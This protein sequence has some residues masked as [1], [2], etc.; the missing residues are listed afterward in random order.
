MVPPSKAP[1]PVPTK[2]AS[3]CRHVSVAPSNNAL[4]PGPSSSVLESRHTP[5]A[6]L[7]NTPMSMR[8]PRRYT[9]SGR[10]T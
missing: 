8:L 2:G 4:D 10:Q 1:T 7:N 9:S 6:P 3:E 5:A